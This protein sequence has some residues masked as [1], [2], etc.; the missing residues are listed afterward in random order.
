[1]VRAC[2][3]NDAPAIRSDC[4]SAGSTWRCGESSHQ[5]DAARNWKECLH[6][7]DAE[8]Y[9][10]YLI[11]LNHMTSS[12]ILRLHLISAAA[13]NRVE[14]KRRKKRRREP[15]TFQ[16]RATSASLPADATFSAVLVSLSIDRYPRLL[17]INFC[18]CACR[19]LLSVYCGLT[20]SFIYSPCYLLFILI[21]HLAWALL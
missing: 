5:R 14:E 15:H 11:N 18:S 8:P 17:I 16:K 7:A 9:S 2:N 6:N 1:M 13:A 20:H 21:H 4:L 10:K 3:N 12:W 19:K